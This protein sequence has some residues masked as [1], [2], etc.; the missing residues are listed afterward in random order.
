MAPVLEFFGGQREPYLIERA[1][2]YIGRGA[3]CAVRL[4]SAGAAERHA[5][6]TMDGAGNVFIQD[7]DTHSGTLRNG[8]FV[9]GVQQLSEG[10]TI[11][12][13]GMSLTFRAAAPALSVAPAAASTSAAAPRSTAQMRASAE[14]R[15]RMPTELPPEVKAALAAR[16]QQAAQAANAPKPPPPVEAAPAGIIVGTPEPEPDN[17]RTVQMAPPDLAALGIDP[18]SLPPIRKPEPKP[19]AAPPPQPPV[20]SAAKRTMM[21]MPAPVLPKPPGAVKPADVPLSP[22]TPNLGYMATAELQAQKLP[23]D[24]PTV[25]TTAPPSTQQRAVTPPPST[26][27]RAVTPPPQ[28]QQRAVTPP[29]QTPVMARH[30]HATAPTMMGVPRPVLPQTSTPVATPPVAPPPAMKTA[31]LEVPV[32]PVAAPAMPPVAAPYVPPSA[33]PK[34]PL[35]PAPQ[36]TPVATGPLPQ[37]AYTPPPKGSFGA[38]SRALAFMGQIFS[39]A[40]K[41]KALGKPL[42]YDVLLTTPIMAAF[43]VLELFVHSR[44]GFYAVMGVEAFL[45]YF[46]DYAC[47]SITASLMYDYAMTGEASMSTAIPRVKKALPGVMTFAAV[48]ALLDLASTYARE[49]NDVVSKIILRVLRAIWTTATYVIMP[50][51]VIEG[52]SF[53]DAFKRSKALMDQ[54][55]TGVGAGVV[56]MSLTSYIVAA[57]CFPLAY[58]LLHAGAHIHPAVGAL[59]SML[60]VNLYWAVSGW[61]KI[62]YATCFYMWARECERTGTTDHALA[63]I[64]LR[65]ALDAA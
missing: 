22:P 39:L 17:F 20:P 46:I 3:A 59:L 57:I 21:G 10:D 31:Q 58:V 49:R 34:P 5:R 54:D 7:L 62:A 63:P 30:P 28:T 42:V 48:S 13:G 41:H 43:T 38:F 6:M 45:L 53:G 14:E 8:N 4:D 11:E 18:A 12:I 52:V 23:T 65:T 56:A 27:Q 26:Q 24:P 40:A 33:Q 37:H 60:I 25:Q 15:T 44:G 64:P 51:L 19:A 36:P 29:P 35:A 2:V 55:P 47:N 16:Q 9:Y 32:V 61:M 1:E 50:A